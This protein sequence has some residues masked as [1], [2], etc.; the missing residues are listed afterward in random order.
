MNYRENVKRVLAAA[1]GP[2]Y[3]EIWR[4]EV[5]PYVLSVAA[6]YAEG[7]RMHDEFSLRERSVYAGLHLR[8][9]LAPQLAIAIH[10]VEYAHEEEFQR[11]PIARAK[12]LYFAAEMWSD[13][14]YDPESEKLGW[15]DEFAEMFGVDFQAP[16]YSERLERYD[17]GFRACNVPRFDLG[18]MTIEGRVT[19]AAIDALPPKDQWTEDE[20]YRFEKHARGIADLDA[21]KCRLKLVLRNSRQLN[22]AIEKKFEA[23]GV[24]RDEE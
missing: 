4:R 23:L 15:K 11:L 16:P 13:G 21:I 14:G 10:R 17:L 12:A 6:T 22:S 1:E 24:S 8:D 5:P 19:D 9:G 18:G 3:E 2:L 7:K 20:K